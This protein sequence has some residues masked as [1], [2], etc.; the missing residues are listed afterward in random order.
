MFKLLSQKKALSFLLLL[1]AHSSF[2]QT[3]S[4]VAGNGKQGYSGDNGVAVNAMLNH[5]WGMAIDD[6]G[7]IY[8]ADYVNSRVRKI[9]ASN[10]QIT[11]IAG[12][13]KNGYNGDNIDARSAQLNAPMS[14]AVDQQGNIYIA[15]DG[16]YRVRKINANN[17]KITTVAG[18][19]L[20][21][22][23]G[24]G[25]PAANAQLGDPWHISVD[26]D[27]NL[28][29][30]DYSNNCIR[31][32]NALNGVIT[33]VAGTGVG[34]YSGDEGLATK[35]S[36]NLPVATAIDSYG[37]V[38]IAD[39]NNNCIRK[40]DTETGIVTTV[41]G[42]GS[43]G[44]S[45]EGVRAVNAVLAYPGGVAIDGD[46]NVY[47]TDSDNERICK[48]NASDGMISIIAG[49]GTGSDSL[50]LSAKLNGPQ[51]IALSSGN[52]Y[53]SD[54]YDFKIKKIN[55][56]YKET[57]VKIVSFSATSSM[58]KLSLQWQISDKCNTNRY[59]MVQ[60]STDSLKW[61]TIKTVASIDRMNRNSYAQTVAAP[62]KAVNYY[63]LIAVNKYN[64]SVYS[65]I[66][67]VDVE[68]PDRSESSFVLYPNPVTQD[69]FTLKIAT[70]LT[71]KIGFTITDLMGRKVLEGVIM[72]QVQVINVNR[73]SSGIYILK[74]SDGRTGKFKKI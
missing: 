64:D 48:I 63:R 23:A 43:Y 28:F 35:A 25:G 12:T 55:N 54:T 17:G 73:F 42:N 21:G 67:K 62:T 45:T 70:P 56:V 71:S 53:F 47:F 65:A 52:L 5:P 26:G 6:L 39:F 58:E 57:P 61:S 38:F 74:L 46:D 2:C 41:A 4:T 18:T 59:F 7:N 72:S 15:D 33:T 36:L 24:D 13:G 49:G 27:N 37:N 29:I 30:T 3:L 19:G 11:T 44:R 20:H 1:L 68:L 51:A 31:K 50:A 60:Y 32:V 34:G 10:G 14:V 8:F 16:N 69:F 40:L 22:Y 9:N 66:Q